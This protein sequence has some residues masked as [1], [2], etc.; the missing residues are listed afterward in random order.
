MQ[1]KNNLKSELNNFLNVP[2]MQ[3]NILLFSKEKNKLLNNNILNQIILSKILIKKNYEYINFLKFYLNQENN[4]NNI[5]IKPFKQNKIN[6]NLSTLFKESTNNFYNYIKLQQQNKIEDKKTN[7]IF[8]FFS[9]RKKKKLLLQNLC[10]KKVQNFYFKLLKK[11]KIN[12]IINV[13]KK[14]QSLDSIKKF[15]KKR[16][17]IIKIRKRKLRRRLIRK[18]KRKLKIM[19]YQTR[20][21]LRKYTQQISPRKIEDTKK[22]TVILHHIGSKRNLKLT[23]T[24]LQG[25]VLAYFSS[26]SKQFKKSRRRTGLARLQTLTKMLLSLKKFKIKRVILCYNRGKFPKLRSIRRTLRRKRIRVIKYIFKSSK[27]H[28]G[29]RKKKPKRK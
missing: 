24:T 29:C 27:P 23:A 26:G 22:R 12:L 7:F 2:Q 20:P 13:N 18:L 21:F 1:K 19:L 8:D 3:K 6:N 15:F 5:F 25:E 17:S 10:L 28:N 9:I 16:K 4:K 11:K 14:H